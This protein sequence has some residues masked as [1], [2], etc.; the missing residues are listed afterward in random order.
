MSQPSLP[1]QKRPSLKL[2]RP[3]EFG[4]VSNL[5][6]T[7]EHGESQQLGQGGASLAINTSTLGVPADPL[8]PK[9]RG[10]ARNTA[11]RESWALNTGHV[12]NLIAATAHAIR[13]GLPLNR[14]VSIH[15][16]AAGVA[17]EDMPKATGRFFDLATKALARRGERTA[18]VWVHENGD[19]KG[20][21][22]HALIHVPIHMSQIITSNQR[23]WL[24]SISGNPYRSS[25]IL[26][27]PVGRRVG[28]EQT[29]PP[30]YAENIK[31]ALAYLVKGADP[32]AKRRFNLSRLEDGGRVLGKRC[33]TSQNIGSK[34]RTC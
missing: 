17:L 34:A 28:L 30:L 11:D 32:A 26:T 1:P 12:G 5:R 33:G 25:V 6:L 4:E 3:P 18:W 16:E 21:H 14:M 20:A 31:A 22:C 9:G 23:R 8:Q 2:H 7:I 29:N 27:R 15:W 13:I 19:H 24:R 10:G